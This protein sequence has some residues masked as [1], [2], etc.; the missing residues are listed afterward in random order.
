M[1]PHIKSQLDTTA[2]AVGGFADF[3]FAFCEAFDEIFVQSAGVFDDVTSFVIEL[4]GVGL[5]ESYG[6]L[7]V[8][9]L[10]VLAEGDPFLDHV[11]RDGCFYDAEIV[12][13][14]LF[15]GEVEEVVGHELASGRNTSANAP[16]TKVIL[17]EKLGY[18]GIRVRAGLGISQLPKKNPS[19]RDKRQ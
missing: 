16:G 1:R 11:Q 13:V 14:Q 7:E 9:P 4:L 18:T 19:P 2:S 17:V 6:V 8:C 12:A 15:A 3:R 5:D 10:G